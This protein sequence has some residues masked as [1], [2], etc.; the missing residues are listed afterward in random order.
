M[1]NMWSYGE[2]VGYTLGVVTV[3][4]LGSEIGSILG[5][6]GASILGAVGGLFGSIIGTKFIT[7]FRNPDTR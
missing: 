5:H 6:W 7:A 3:A 4:A 2:A 1:S